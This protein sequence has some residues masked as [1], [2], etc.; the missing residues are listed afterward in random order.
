MMLLVVTASV[1]D[2]QPAIPPPPVTPLEVA[3]AT[4]RSA[5]QNGELELAARAYTEAL[6]LDE[7]PSLLCEAAELLLAVGRAT[8]ARALADRAHA[9]TV[10]PEVRRRAQGITLR[11]AQHTAPVVSPVAAVTRSTMPTLTPAPP[12]PAPIRERGQPRFPFLR[13][14]IEG[15]LSR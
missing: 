9:T 15:V 14:I 1:A 7:D 10:V 5:V 2:A 6:E 8:E 3:V 12:P 4:A 13:A 11:S